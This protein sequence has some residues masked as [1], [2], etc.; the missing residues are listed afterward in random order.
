MRID[1]GNVVLGVA[2]WFIFGVACSFI[3]E[4]LG[5]Q[6]CIGS[7]GF[8][9]GGIVAL[10]NRWT[11]IVTIAG[12]G[13]F[14]GVF[15]FPYATAEA[16]VLGPTETPAPAE[17]TTASPTPTP[18]ETQAPAPPQPLININMLLVVGDPEVYGMTQTPESAKLLAEALSAYQVP[19]TTDR[20]ATGI[21]HKLVIRGW[22][23]SWEG[24]SPSFRINGHRVSTR[25][26]SGKAGISG[27]LKTCSGEFI[28][29]RQ[30]NATASATSVRIRTLS[31]E[32][33]TPGRAL[34]QEAMVKAA[35]QYARAL[36]RHYCIPLDPAP[37]LQ[38]Q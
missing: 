3:K 31:L 21:S 15:L 29:S 13:F 16:I 2:I 1:W 7:L 8:C 14:A 24:L 20:R 34:E 9:L 32:N 27:H 18:T 17:T 28:W 38:Y 5:A 23:D 22:S 35:A 25:N 33:N 10:P 4:D 37:A 36:A 26:R 12:I 30:A 6:I 11:A 19:V